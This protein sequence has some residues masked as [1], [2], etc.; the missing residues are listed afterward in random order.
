VYELEFRKQQPNSDEKFLRDRAYS[1]IVQAAV[2]GNKVHLKR[3]K[4]K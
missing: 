1:H 2:E 3:L 4:R